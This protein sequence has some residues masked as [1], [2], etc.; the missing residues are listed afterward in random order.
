MSKIIKSG[1]RIIQNNVLDDIGFFGS[2][3]FFILNILITFFIN[4]KLSIVLLVSFVSLMFFVFLIRLIYYKDRPNKENHT[5]LI[6][7]ID[8]SSFP[9]LH[10]ARA[11][12]V[13]LIYSIFVNFNFP[14]TIIFLVLAISTG[15]SR[16]HKK[17]HDFIDV[18]CGAIL[19]LI[20]T[21]LIYFLII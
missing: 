19:G 5:N 8:A 12:S 15:A 7:K 3:L 9:S 18:T 6:E 1:Y 17:K 16:M 21:Y 2:F 14:L 4:I 11:F 10:A 13:A 20:V